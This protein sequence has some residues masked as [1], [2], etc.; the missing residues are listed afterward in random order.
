[1]ELNEVVIIAS[2]NFH[3]KALIEPAGDKQIK[4]QGIY[5]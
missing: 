3:T 5:S 2:S 1:M 4:V